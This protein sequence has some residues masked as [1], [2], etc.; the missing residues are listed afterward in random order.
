MDTEW[1]VTE[2][3]A[4]DADALLENVKYGVIKLSYCEGLSYARITSQVPSAGI[5]FR[6]DIFFIIKRINYVFTRLIT[7]IVILWLLYKIMFLTQNTRVEENQFTW[8]TFIAHTE[9]M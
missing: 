1:M 6:A 5:W 8:F 9:N 3:R 7:N 4:A 2:T